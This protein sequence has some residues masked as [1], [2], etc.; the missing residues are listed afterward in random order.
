[1]I[2][3]E[4]TGAFNPEAA[5]VKAAVAGLGNALGGLLRI[6]RWSLM[7]PQQASSIKIVL[8]SQ[9]HALGLLTFSW[10]Y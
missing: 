6:V 2:E 8:H 10:C 4:A 7:Q 5:G 9:H 3:S 1:M